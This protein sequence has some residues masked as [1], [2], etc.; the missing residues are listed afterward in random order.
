MPMDDN[1]WDNL[2]TIASRNAVSTDFA[3]AKSQRGSV[4]RYAGPRD[5]CNKKRRLV[6]ILWPIILKQHNIIGN[7]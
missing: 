1:S 6:I 2:S 4:T 5:V 7:C 3:S